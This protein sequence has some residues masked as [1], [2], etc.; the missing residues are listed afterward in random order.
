MVAGAADAEGAPGAAPTG[1]RVRG[2]RAG[3]RPRRPIAWRRAAGLAV[4]AV[5]LATSAGA[6]QGQDAPARRAASPSGRVLVGL[7]DTRVLLQESPGRSKAESEF[8]LEQANMR[9]HVREAA[10][11]L[12]AAVEQFTRAEGTL[13]PREREALMM[14]LR[15]RELAFEDMVSQLNAAAETKLQTLQAPF[16]E[17][18]RAAVRTVRQREGVHL[19]LDA[20]TMPAIIDADETID[21]TPKVLAEL[22]RSP[23]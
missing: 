12:K 3:T 17:K 21:L 7:V 6:L 8:A 14:V 1:R 10:D 18:I 5:V 16:V 4:F 2:A 13:R 19:V 15:A 11:S 20:A 22:R 23:P 9:V